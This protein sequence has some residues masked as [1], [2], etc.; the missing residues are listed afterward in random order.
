MGNG[1]GRAIAASAE[2]NAETEMS[3]ADLADLAVVDDDLS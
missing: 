2:E 3:F 1:S